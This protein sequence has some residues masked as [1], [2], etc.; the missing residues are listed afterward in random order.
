MSDVLVTS[1]RTLVFCGAGLSTPSGIPDYRSGYDTKLKTG[2]G[3][4]EREKHNDKPYHKPHEKRLAIQA[5]PN[6][7]HLALKAL[8]QNDLVSHFVSQNVDGLLSKAMISD[9]KISELHGNLFKE[10]CLSCGTEYWRDFSTVKKNQ[11]RITE[12]R[13]LCTE[14]KPGYT[15]DV[16]NETDLNRGSEVR[17][18]LVYFGDSLQ[19]EDLEKSAEEMMESD[20]CFSIG[21]SMQV[22][23]AANIVR[24]F[25]NQ[26]KKVAILNLQRT[27]LH[28]DKTINIHSFCDV[29][30]DAVRKNLGLVN[31]KPEF[32]RDLS[33][34]KNHETGLYEFCFYDFEN[35]PIDIA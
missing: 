28:S 32:Y 30:L 31:P 29:F 20:F 22:T 3:K 33:I 21:S 12:R 6:K 23:P 17:V 7:G 2:P 4:W 35:K 24:N 13:C 19:P 16:K 10:R 18:S 8:E 1:K 25:I 9:D 11:R 26:G 34:E 14:G 5:W 27:N 15:I